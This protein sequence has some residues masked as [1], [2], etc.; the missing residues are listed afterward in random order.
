MIT[1]MLQQANYSFIM[2]LHVFVII[3]LDNVIIVNNLFCLNIEHIL[4]ESNNHCVLIP[5]I[6]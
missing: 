1:Y 6:C 4:F 5:S 2:H 3:D